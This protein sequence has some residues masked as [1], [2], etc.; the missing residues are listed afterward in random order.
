MVINSV[1]SLYRMSQRLS[2]ISIQPSSI[3]CICGKKYSSIPML[4]NGQMMR[5]ARKTVY[6]Y[7][8]FLKE[9]A[10]EIY[11]KNNSLVCNN[12][13]LDACSF[14]CFFLI[15]YNIKVNIIINAHSH[16]FFFS[17][18]RQLKQAEQHSLCN[19]FSLLWDVLLFS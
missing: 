15:L 4:S 5:Y 10:I 11:V 8:V 19:C 13:L 12:L 3:L 14:E 1:S 16:L 6:C 2:T 17:L 18:S 9:L 7:C